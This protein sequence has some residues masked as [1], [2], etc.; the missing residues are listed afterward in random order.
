M[1]LLAAEV[2]VVRTDRLW[3]R[4][5]VQP[6]PNEADRRV[7]ER[8][9]SEVEGPVVEGPVVEGPVV[10]GGADSDVSVSRAREEARPPSP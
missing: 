1:T 3:P 7:F 6:P 8:A 2:N 4:S 5:L 9:V 10:G